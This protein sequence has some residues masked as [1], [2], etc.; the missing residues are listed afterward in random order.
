MGVRA[1]RAL[2][3]RGAQAVPPY[4]RQPLDADNLFFVQEREASRRIVDAVEQWRTTRDALQE[5]TV[6]FLFGVGTTEQQVNR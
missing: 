5:A 3:C 2:D 1:R 4:A 6:T